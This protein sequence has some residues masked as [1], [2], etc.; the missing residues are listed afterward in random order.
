M[1]AT[2]RI[3]LPAWAFS[4]WQDRYFDSRDRLRQYASVFST[5]EGNTTFY[6]TP[7]P[8]TVRDWHAQIRDLDFRFCFKLPKT[9]THQ[10]G[11]RQA[12]AE[13]LTALRPLESHLG[14]FLVQLPAVVGP[15]HV[16]WIRGLLESLPADIGYALEVRH[17]D[18][19]QQEGDFDRY[20]GD[21]SCLRTIMD[22]RPIHLEGPTHPEVLAARHEKPDLPVYVEPGPLGA[23]IRL[24]LHP[25][26]SLNEAYYRTW[27]DAAARW[28]EEGRT[29]F[30]M[31][32]CPNN[33]HCPPQARRFQALVAGQTGL[34]DTLPD[35]P[36][37]Q[38]SLFQ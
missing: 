23:M 34:V 5:V 27:T 19:F 18:F 8:A 7:A 26:D 29:V 3:G 12:L 37:P 1:N 20:F 22:A 10:P 35:W 9:V 31:I 38:S 21:L 24:V 14:P 32:H 16:G 13:F 15:E 6:A 36:L 33:L 4:G 17:P 2:Y 28:L 30:M 25:D 11:G